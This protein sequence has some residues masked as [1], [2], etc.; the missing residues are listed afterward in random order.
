MKAFI[1]LI[2]T[3]AVA[4]AE[5]PQPKAPAVSEADGYVEIPNVALPPTR[6]NKY[7]RFL[8]RRVPP[9]RQPNWCPH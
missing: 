2:A 3:V 7:R 8:M 6:E 9:K 1:I 5:W 4:A